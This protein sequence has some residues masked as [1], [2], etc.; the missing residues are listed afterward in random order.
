MVYHGRVYHSSCG[1]GVSGPLLGCTFLL[2]REGKENLHHPVAY[3]YLWGTSAPRHCRGE[4]K[5]SYADMGGTAGGKHCSS[6][7]PIAASVSCPSLKVQTFI[8]RKSHL[9]S[10]FG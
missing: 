1:V 2:H 10:G 5:G 3:L 7:L 6:L 4:G 8:G 9:S